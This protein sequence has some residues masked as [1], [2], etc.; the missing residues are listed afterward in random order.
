MLVHLLRACGVVVVAGFVLFCLICLA[1]N[2]VFGLILKFNETNVC[3]GIWSHKYQSLLVVFAMF[4]CCG[5]DTLFIALQ[6]LQLLNSQYMLFLLIVITC[7][8]SKSCENPEWVCQWQKVNFR[9]MWRDR[10]ENDGIQIPSD[11]C[12]KSVLKLQSSVAH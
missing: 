4:Q 9:P 1:K 11:N 12:T 6:V 3:W 5:V 2:E 7:S 8:F 10:K